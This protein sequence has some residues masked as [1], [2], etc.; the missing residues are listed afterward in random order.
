MTA[1]PIPLQVKIIGIGA[2]SPGHVTA[3]AADAVKDQ[4]TTAARDVQEHA[5]DATTT[6]ADHHN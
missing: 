5:H 1:D 3:D 2:G 4:S 6:V